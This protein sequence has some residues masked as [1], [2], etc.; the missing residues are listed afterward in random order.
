MLFMFLPPATCTGPRA[1]WRSTSIDWMQGVFTG[2]A[3]YFAIQGQAEGC[4]GKRDR[5]RFCGIFI[6][7]SGKDVRGSELPGRSPRRWAGGFE[8][9]LVGHKGPWEQ[10]LL[11]PCQDFWACG[12][13][14]QIVFRAV[15]K[16]QEELDSSPALKGCG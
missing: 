5:E 1:C 16:V 6:G 14:Q 4:N 10:G 2:E 9:F 13:S 7:Y 8:L 11:V 12:I 15:G 3:W